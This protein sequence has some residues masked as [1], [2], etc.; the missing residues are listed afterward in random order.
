M[1]EKSRRSTLMMTPEGNLI[2]EYHDTKRQ[3]FVPFRIDDQGAVR[4]SA[5]R[6]LDSL[7]LQTETFRGSAGRAPPHIQRAY[8]VLLTR[9]HADID[10]Y[11][12]MC[13]VKTS[14]AWSYLCRIL[15]F[16]P[17]AN[18]LASRLVFQPLLVALL[19]VDSTS[20]LKEVMERL[21][22]GPLKGDQEWRALEHRFA[23]LRLARMCLMNE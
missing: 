14:T 1:L 20:S 19:S 9:E 4:L 8:S 12:T 10:E 3:H 18:V 11:A 6:S 22:S 16:Y 23:H 17:S 15:E 13:T 2:R 7:I 5:N 21:N